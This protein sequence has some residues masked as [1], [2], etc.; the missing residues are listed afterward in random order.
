MVYPNP[1]LLLSIKSTPTFV[2]SNQ[3]LELLGRDSNTST[4]ANSGFMKLTHSSVG[5]RLPVGSWHL[6]V[7]I[8]FLIFTMSVS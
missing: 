7:P 8:I 2:L 4:A 3:S 6:T 1:I 5:F